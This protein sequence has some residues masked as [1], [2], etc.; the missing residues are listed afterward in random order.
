MQPL[1]Q[2]QHHGWN[3][4]ASKYVSADAAVDTCAVCRDRLFPCVLCKRLIYVCGI[5]C[6]QIS[7]YFLWPPLTSHRLSFF[8]L[9]R[10]LS[11]PLWKWV[12]FF[13]GLSDAAE[14]AGEVLV[15]PPPPTSDPSIVLR[16]YTQSD[17]YDITR[18]STPPPPPIFNMRNMLMF[19]TPAGFF[20][21]YYLHFNGWCAS[22]S[23]P[24]R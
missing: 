6:A 23:S 24:H 9:Q 11:S 4:P 3:Y 14:D 5:V 20:L 12:I 15:L 17:T 7:R 2:K 21:Y 16:G 1:A 10:S 22:L 19:A 13:G 18:S 8:H